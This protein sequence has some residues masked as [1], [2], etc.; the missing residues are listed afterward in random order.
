MFPKSREI[1]KHCFLAMFSKG[2][3]TKKHY[4]LCLL[5]TDK[6]R[7][8]Y[9]L[10]MFPRG[11]DQETLFPSHVFLFPEVGKTKKHCFQVIF[12]T[13][14]NHCFPGIF[15][16]KANKKKTMFPNPCFL[17]VEKLGNIVSWPYFMDVDTPRNIVSKSQFLNVHGKTMKHCFLRGLL[18][19]DKQRDVSQL[20][21]TKHSSFSRRKSF[22]P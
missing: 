2:E 11:E 8:H 10:A 15:R 9:M 3:Q 18:K 20:T 5:T 22:F 13:L 21:F 12:R 1:R 6:P 16:I 7:K 17:K 19:V 4:F 14:T